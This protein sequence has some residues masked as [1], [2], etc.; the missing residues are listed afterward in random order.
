[1]TVI[2]ALKRG[3]ILLETSPVVELGKDLRIGLGGWKFTMMAN[4]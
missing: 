1:M 2:E 3:W 4:L